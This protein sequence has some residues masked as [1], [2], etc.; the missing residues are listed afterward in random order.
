MVIKICS[1][2][3]S[4]LIKVKLSLLYSVNHNE[5]NWA[6]IEKEKVARAHRRQF[7]HCVKGNKSSRIIGVI[8][9]FRRGE[10]VK[11][12]YLLIR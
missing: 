8:N 12:T 6:G 9:V 1:R 3:K 10:E 4:I 5:G 11:D 2:L 7:L